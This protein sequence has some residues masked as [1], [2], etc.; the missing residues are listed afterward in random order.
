MRAGRGS[1]RGA[2]MRERFCGR[3]AFKDAEGFALRM[4]EARKHPMRV[5]SF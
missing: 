1:R 5:A 2:G 4:S 3:R